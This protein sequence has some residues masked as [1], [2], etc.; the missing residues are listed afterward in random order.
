MM[1]EHGDMTA[2]GLKQTLDAFEWRQADLARK[3]R[4]SPNTVSRWASD[5]PPAWVGEYLQVM[6]ELDRLH[7]LYIRP[8]RVER[9]APAEE[10]DSLNPNSRAGRMAR[11]LVAEAWHGGAPKP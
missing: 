7:R 6:L 11:R 2:E 5:G 10:D 9:A 8:P 1:H 3:L 4:V